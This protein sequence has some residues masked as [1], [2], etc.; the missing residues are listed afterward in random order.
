MAPP[1]GHPELEAPIKFHDSF[2][3]IWRRLSHLIYSDV[4]N[5]H[6]NIMR[7]PV[8]ALLQRP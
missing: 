3:I 2:Q 8:D 5:G 1:G 6:L 7:P 4:I